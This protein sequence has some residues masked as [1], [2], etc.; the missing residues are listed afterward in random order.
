MT[1]NTPR[2]I[3]L[4]YF[5]KTSLKSQNQSKYKFKNYS[6]HLKKFQFSDL[7]VGT[8]SWDDRKYQEKEMIGI[9]LKSYEKFK[10]IE[11]IFFYCKIQF[12]QKKKFPKAIYWWTKYR[13]V[14]FDNAS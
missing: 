3:Y 2:R 13:F 12:R 1:Q 5:E 9:F 6:K 11:K 14:N 7:D 8:L 4:H 10:L